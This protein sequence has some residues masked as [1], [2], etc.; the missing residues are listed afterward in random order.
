M[1]SLDIIAIEENGIFTAKHNN[2][3][4]HVEKGAT[5]VTG[6]FEG[7]NVLEYASRPVTTKRAF[8]DWVLRVYF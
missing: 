8:V 1:N 7:R 6:R 5:L 4:W 2:H 3:Y